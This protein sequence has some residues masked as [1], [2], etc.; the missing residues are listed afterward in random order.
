MKKGMVAGLLLVSGLASAQDYLDYKMVSTA[1]NPFP[2]YVDSTSNTP[3]GLQYTLMQNAVERAWAT[4]NAVQCAYPKV[5][6]L[7]PSTGTV[8]SPRDTFDNFSVTPVWMLVNDADAQQ[9]FGNTNLITAITLPRAYA[10]VLQTC[11]VFFNGFNGLWSTDSAVGTDRLDVETVM[12]HEAGHCLGLGHSGG[13]STVMDQ[14]VE[15][16]LAVRT[17][18][19]PDVQKL[20]GRY[21]IAGESA[22]PCFADGGCQQ[23]DLKCLPQPTTNGLNLTLCSKGCALG[24]NALCDVPQFCQPSNEFTAGGFNGACL[25]P[26]GIATQVGRSCVATPDCGNSVGYCQQP[27]PASGGNMFWVDGYC[28]QSCEPGQPLCPAGSSCQ[29]LGIGKRCLQS[30][31]VGLADCRVNYACAQVDAL[32]TTGV[33]VPRCSSDQDCADPVTF[34]CRTCD[35]L[36]VPRQ[37]PAG[38]LG[39]PCLADTECG[40]GQVCRITALTSNQKQCVRQCSRGC[41]MCP[42]GSTCTPAARGELFCLRDCTGPGTC[43]PGLRCAD[44]QV[45]KSCLPA[46]TSDTQCPVGQYCLG[47]E[48]ETP[49]EGDGGCSVLQCRPDAGRPISAVPKDAGSGGGGSEGGAGSAGCGCS[50]ANSAFGVALLGLLAFLSRRRQC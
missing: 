47:G 31:R 1:R 14:V 6:S 7:G 34:T 43:G 9:I 49:L 46:C 27:E 28:T 39:D 23:T 35:G 38:A 25:L 48:C 11:D 29:Q 50:S 17:L 30:C 19:A 45:G 42:T 32:A 2:V 13:S 15:R 44:T 3:G 22:S 41:G 4:W 37:N 26:G 33:C 5:T 36:C 40:A 16:G 24:T 12:L 18:A 20:C 21:P 10:G 8:Q